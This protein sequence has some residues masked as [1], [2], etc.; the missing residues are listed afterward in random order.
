MEK[1][2]QIQTNTNNYKEFMF[3]LFCFVFL[4]ILFF[5]SFPAGPGW[6]P[7]GKL[8]QKITGSKT[9]V[10]Y[11][12]YFLAEPSRKILWG[13]PAGPGRKQGNTRKHKQTNKHWIF[14]YL[15][16]IF[17]VCFCISLF[18][19]LLFLGISCNSLFE[20]LFFGHFLVLICW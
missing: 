11:R 19:C 3:C 20:L 8:G 6:S 5:L 4:F 7:A 18:C 10:L 15:F 17:V 13:S 12:F 1:S 2:K 16:P 9:M 14:L